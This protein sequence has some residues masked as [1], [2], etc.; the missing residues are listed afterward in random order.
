[1]AS[2][3]RLSR[4]RLNDGREL[5]VRSAM[6]GDAR[7]VCA[8]LDAVGAEAETPILHVSGSCSVR[9][10]RAEVARVTTERGTLM[11]VA[12]LEKGVVGHLSLAADRHP[13]APHV[14]ELGLVVQRDLRGRGIG[15]ALLD[16]AL[17]WAGRHGFVRVTVGVFSHNERALRF[18]TVH[19]FVREALLTQRFERLQR[20]YDEVLMARHLTPSDYAVA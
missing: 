10:L 19:G 2:V 6:P 5:A 16:V 3:R 13:Y 11:L 18:F 8:L 14:C 20:R 7:G 9:T 1:M 15:S 17:P 12:L 4:F